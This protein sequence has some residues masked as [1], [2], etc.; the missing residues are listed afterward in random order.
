M[1]GA[2]LARAAA[3]VKRTIAPLDISAAVDLHRGAPA[4]LLTTKVW[5]SEI[6]DWPRTG[7]CKP[8]A[9]NGLGLA[10]S[11]TALNKRKCGARVWFAR[12]ESAVCAVG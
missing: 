7:G 6:A 9:V 11:G 5:G 8:P 3:K 2:W 1:A 12:G 4:G 10:R